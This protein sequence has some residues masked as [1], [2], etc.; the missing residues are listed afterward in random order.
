MLRASY[1]QYVDQL[2]A[3]AVSF[4]LPLGYTGVQY[5]WDDADGDDFVDWNDAAGTGELVDTS[6]NGTVGCE[7]AQSFFGI[8]PCNTAAFSSPNLISPDL[9]PP[10]LDEFIIGAEYELAQ[11]FTLGLNYTFRQKD[12]F[13]WKPYYDPNGNLT[14]SGATP[15][16]GT[17]AYEI[18]GTTG[19]TAPDGSSQYEGEYWVLTPGADAD[20][21]TTGRGRLQTNNPG[22]TQEF[23]GIELVATK[24][25]SNKWRMRAFLMYSEWQQ[26]F[27]GDLPLNPGLYGRLAQN[28]GD[29]TNYRGGTTDDGGLIAVQSQ[30]SGNKRD[31]FVGSS[32]WQFNVNGLYQLPMNWSVSGNIYG[33]EGY[34]LGDYSVSPAT[35]EGF[36]SLQNGAIDSVRYDDLWMVDLRVAKTWLL[37]QNTNVELAGE[38]FNATNENTVLQQDQRMDAT[39]FQRIGEIVSPRV[40]RIVATVNF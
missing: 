38:L 5:L 2:D 34:G 16:V 27:D 10:R 32:T 26:K 31:V 30:S 22:Y 37:G 7:D 33:R 25:L 12:D 11:D 18:G 13:L 28:S 8:D 1:G 40:L 39:T 17:D 6:G 24:R 20:L 21:D 3:S 19:G 9:D 35:S 14:A 23:N 36:K 15:F 29:P 4:N